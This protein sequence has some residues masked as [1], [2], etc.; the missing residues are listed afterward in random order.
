[1]WL[2]IVSI[3]IIAVGVS[4]N[5]VFVVTNIVSFSRVVIADRSLT[6]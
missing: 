6:V 1:M 3:V 5:I 4:M 2:G